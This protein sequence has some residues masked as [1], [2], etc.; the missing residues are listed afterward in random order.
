MVEQRTGLKR[1][2]AKQFRFELDNTIGNIIKWEAETRQFP[3]RLRE[4][5]FIDRRRKIEGN[6]SNLPPSEQLLFSNIL[7]LVAFKHGIGRLNRIYRK[8]AEER[9]YIGSLGPI[10]VGKSTLIETLKDDLR[11]DYVA[12]EPL[13]NNPFWQ[14]SLGDRDY[15]LR[16]QTYFLLA[17]IFSD[18]EAKRGRAESKIAVSD[19]STWADALMWVEWYRKTGKIE[20]RDYETYQKLFALLKDA[21]P[22]PDLLVAMAPNSVD[23]LYRGFLNR[24]KKDKNR[25]K[26]KTFSKQDVRLLTEIASSLSE[27]IS[28]ELHIPVLRIDNIDPVEMYENPHLRYD[29]IYQIRRELG[30]LGELLKPKP[31]KV[32]NDAVRMLLAERGQPKVIIIH[33]KSMFTG[34][35]TSLCFLADKVGRNKVI[36]FQPLAAIRDKRQNEAIL[37]RDGPAI[38]SNLV[39]NND[40]WSI[41][42]HIKKNKI[43]PKKKPY[44]FIDEIELFIENALDPKKDDQKKAVAALKELQKMGFHVVVDGIDYTF[45]EEPFTFMH[46]LLAQVDNSSW[47]AIETSTRCR[48]CHET[49]QGTRRWVRRGAQW[50]IAD[51]HDQTYVAGSE[52]YEPVCCK[53]HQSC[54]NQ[55]KGFKKKGLHS[56]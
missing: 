49:A 51:Y 2:E 14:P 9:R 54:R 20:E 44:I 5:S 55:P 16:S 18:M 56:L 42:D 19:T 7:D 29:Y 21:I 10:A 25:R 41:V 38:K 13:R 15:M 23:N 22:R 35:T 12:R 24:M 26:E 46:D 43:S 11:A 39:R 4:L 45:Q 47:F 37:S 27:S 1:I 8:N 52:I 53:N 32:V 28:R 40:L 50:K 33:A 3:K 31:E 17:N 48:Y 6:V 34:K 36:A 30:L